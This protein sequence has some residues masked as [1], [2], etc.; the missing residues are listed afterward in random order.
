M[1]NVK[2]LPLRRQR[3]MRSVDDSQVFQYALTSDATDFIKT[4][5]L[6][7]LM[8]RAQMSSNIG[9]WS[10][11]TIEKEGTQYFFQMGRYRSVMPYAPINDEI[12]QEAL[13]MAPAYALV[14]N[15]S[16]G[17]ASFSMLVE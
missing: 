7:R 16:G 13:S 9:Q 1:I 14:P 4:F 5:I 15:G 12:L 2:K 17:K 6:P 8:S 11:I 3:R 10:T